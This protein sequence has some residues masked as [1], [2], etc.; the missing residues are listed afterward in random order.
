[1]EEDLEH[2]NTFSLFGTGAGAAAVECGVAA[3]WQQ[4]GTEFDRQFE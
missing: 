2:G 3:A 1:M 4:C